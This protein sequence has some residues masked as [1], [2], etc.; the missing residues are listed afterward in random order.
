MEFN[1]LIR[2]YAK[3]DPETATREELEEKAVEFGEDEGAVK[4]MSLGNVLDSI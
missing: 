3:I 2:E 4:K 1:D